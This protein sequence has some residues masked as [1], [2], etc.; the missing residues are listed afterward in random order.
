LAG[1]ATNRP[2][3]Q[4]L[5]GWRL[6]A[7]AAPALA[8]GAL[9]T[10]L[11]VYLPAHYSSYVG[12]DLAAVGFAFFL[13]RTLDIGLDPLVGLLVDR[14]QSRWGQFRP[15]MVF[16]AVLVSLSSAVLFLAQPGDGLPRLIAG[17]LLV[18]AAVSVTGVAHP[19]WAARLSA[20]YDDRSRIYSWIYV[21]QS[22]GTFLLLA[23]PPV[24][25]GG[26]TPHPGADVQ[27]MGWALIITMPFLMAAAIAWTPELRRGA[28]RH[29][30]DDVRV[31]DYLR[32]LER[33]AM[34]RLFVA[35]V[36]VSLATGASIGLFV[37]FFRAR[38]LGMTLINGM[39][40]IYLA[41]AIVSVPFWTWVAGRIGKHRA[42]IASAGGY[43]VAILGMG[44][45]RAQL[46]ALLLPTLAFMGLTFA[47]SAF[48]IRAMAAD[49]AD[50]AR[51]HTGL[52]RLGQVYGLLAA[53][54]K[55]GSALALG[56]SFWLL[57]RLGF[58]AAD[59]A[60]SAPAALT[61]LSILYI[62]VPALLMSCAAGVLVGYP[63]DAGEH[64]RIAHELDRKSSA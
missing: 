26:R 17:L 34:R 37:F 4:R 29:A 39:V 51:L 57:A 36:L 63:I 7:F 5:G 40:L 23:L 52:D 38:G 22:V 25:A 14:T 35:D 61:A 50:E 30:A 47:A 64:A 12:L 19:A 43:V 45:I 46:T 8:T 3:L 1:A 33:P 44:V 32:L 16:G 2:A 41:A 9:N 24:L 54:Q 13:V 21:A 27:N 10:P 20:G 48:L 42:L 59:P 31:A 6:A 60:R 11:A 55:I 49:A 15:W 56:V 18:Y 28:P 53:T 58:T 62:G